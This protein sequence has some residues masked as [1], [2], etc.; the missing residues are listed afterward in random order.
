VHDETSFGTDRFGG[1]ASRQ[2]LAAGE[3]QRPVGTGSLN[4]NLFPARNLTF[5]NQTAISHTRMSGS[6]V[7]TQIT[8]GVA[9]EPAIPFQFLGL[10][11]LSNASDLDY[12]PFRWLGVRLGY[13]YS[14]RRI[15][16][17]VT[18][19]AALGAP[20]V[21]QE[22]GLHTGV[23]G[24][25]L[26]PFKGFTA[27][28]DGEIGRADQPFFP[29]SGRNFQAF[30]GRAE[31]R[32]NTLRFAGYVRTDYNV[33]SSSLSVFSARSRQYG[34]DATWTASRRFFI[35]ASYAKLHLD[36]LGTLNYFSRTGATNAFV[37]DQS[38]YVSNLHNANL[39]AHFLLRDRVDFTFGLSHVEDTGDGRTTVTGGET[40]GAIPFFKSAQTFPL[41]FTSPQGKVSVKINDDLRW[42]AG[43]QHYGYAEDFSATQNFRAHT[44]YTSVTWSF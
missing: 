4:V 21:E 37:A 16:S 23:L 19:D 34:A 15:R 5:T 27:N 18:P 8:N 17:Q 6:S 12:R 2:V 43:Y 28:V 33:N 20:L 9:A 14:T 31:Y 32:T 22:N 7:F 24:L 39:S 3:A 11:T 25:R 40:A 10:R 30:R 26:R 44:G 35:D 29:V 13:Q 38:L 42:N 1:N 36:T 41:R